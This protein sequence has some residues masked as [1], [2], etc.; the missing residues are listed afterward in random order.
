M[1]DSNILATQACSQQQCGASWSTRCEDFVRHPQLPRD[2]QFPMS[3]QWVSN[4][5]ASFCTA[6]WHLVT[7]LHFQSCFAEA[8]LTAPPPPG[9]RTMWGSQRPRC[10]SEP[11]GSPIIV[12]S[13]GVSPGRILPS[14]ESRV[15]C[16]QLEK[17]MKIRCALPMAS[18]KAS[19]KAMH[20]STIF[21]MCLTVQHT[22]LHFQDL[23]DLSWSFYINILQISSSSMAR[24][25]ARFSTSTTTERHVARL[26][27]DASD[28]RSHHRSRSP[29]GAQRCG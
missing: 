19:K 1:F 24:H 29:G 17:A 20:N 21:N 15:P 11:L 18:K 4:E 9:G 12:S 28:A 14:R 16:V 5:F 2:G 22:L 10:N 8:A 26:P 13:R 25:G 6:L 27:G 23:L 7:F 3:F